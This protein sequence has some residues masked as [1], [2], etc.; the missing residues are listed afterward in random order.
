MTTRLHI[1]GASGYGAG[2]IVRYLQNHPHFE[3][4]TLESDSAANTPLSDTFPELRRFAAGSRRFDPRGTVRARVAAGDIVI[5]AG[6][7]ELALAEAP[8]LLELGARILDLS[9]GFR[10]K[11]NER[12]AVY[13]F[14]ERYREQIATA[15]LV[16]N[17]G[18][19]PTTSMLALWPLAKF[20]K[21]I[22]TIILDIKSGISGAGRNPKT[23]SL[24]AELEGEVRPYGLTG[25]RHVPE[26]AQELAS[27]GITAP[28]TFS[29]Q[30][31][32]IARGMI[33]SIYVIFN[34][35]PTFAEIDAAYHAQYDNARFV[36]LLPAETAPSL[37]A[38][39][40]SNNAE[41]SYS[42]QGSTLRTFCAIDNLGKG[43]A[44]QAV[45]NLNIMGG[46]PE[47]TSLT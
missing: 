6:S 40:R 44:G 14:S 12:G 42:L 31:V 43:A 9:D 2:E 36:T 21:R 32:P 37:R 19:F 38:V 35:A 1:L 22:N 33:G 7:H 24:L 27:I 45:Q 47:E 3:I 29:P 25:H 17:P 15:K 5:L 13:G 10:L 30:V 41:L 39:S 26:I 34:D 20:A 28:F 4:V 46:Y 18:C 8:A 23:G 11:W 16:A